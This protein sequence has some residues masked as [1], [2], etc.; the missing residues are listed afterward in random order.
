MAPE[1]LGA[2]YALRSLLGLVA[3]VVSLWVFGLV[4]DWACNEP[5]RSET[6]A[7]GL[8]R[9]SLGIGA[10]LGPLMTLKLRSL[11]EANDRAGGRR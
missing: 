2:P 7:W 1:Y 3:G 8:A 9:S 4:I 11:P 10:L 5:L 6:T